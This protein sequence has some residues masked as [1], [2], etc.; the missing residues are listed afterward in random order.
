[1]R[2]LALVLALSA[3]PALADWPEARERAA[4]AFAEGDC[5]AGWQVLWDAAKA[6]ED[7]ARAALGSAPLTL[8][9]DYPGPSQDDLTRLSVAGILALHG[10]RTGEEADREVALALLPDALRQSAEGAAL[11]EC[12]AAP[13]GAAACV[14]AAV[15]DG[16]APPFDAFAAW[17]D[18][19][20]ALEGAAPA[21]CEP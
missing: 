18:A 14:D 7:A 9:L 15:E 12:L 1:M 13:G 6:G 5:A 17:I 3:T 19:G 11:A 4:A 20:A 10:A 8:R 21:R 2:R 16:L